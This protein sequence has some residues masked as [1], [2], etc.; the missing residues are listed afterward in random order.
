MDEPERSERRSSALNSTLLL[1]AGAAA[2]IVV[3][4]LIAERSLG[5]RRLLRRVRGALRNASRLATVWG[6]LQGGDDSEHGDA[7]DTDDETSTD[8]ADEAPS[9]DALDERVLAAFEQDPILVRRAIEIDTPAAGTVVLRG[10]VPSVRDSAH[11]VT[12]ARGI[13]GVER[14]EDRMRVRAPR[15]RA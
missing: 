14:V 13:P 3:G 5:R 1:A 7:P 10:R 12:I 11:A 15:S 2:G 9:G 4:L 8:T 6:A